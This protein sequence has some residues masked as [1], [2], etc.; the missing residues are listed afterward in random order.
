[1]LLRNIHTKAYFHLAAWL[2]FLLI[3]LFSADELDRLFILKSLASFVPP[4]F[5]FYTLIFWVFPVYLG[6]DN[7]IKTIL[8]TA[9]LAIVMVF[10]R[11]LFTLLFPADL[12]TPFDRITFWVQ[13]RYNI[14]FVAIAFGY[15]YAT[16]IIKSNQKSEWLEKEN[17]AAK[18]ALLKQQ[19]NPHFLYNTLSMNYTKA[20][21]LSDEL[22]E[23]IAKLSDMMRYSITETDAQGMVPLANEIKFI[24]Q[25][26]AMNEA[27]FN[28][29]GNCVFI[30]KSSQ[31]TFKIAP[32]LLISFVENAYKH[33]DLAE[34]IKIELKEENCIFDFS[35]ENKIAKG[36]KDKTSGIGLENIKNRLQLLYKNRHSLLITSNDTDYKIELKLW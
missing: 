36:P 17:T 1:L 29:I 19:I 24:G 3:I 2:G 32:L 5:L 14:L 30:I 21:P 7:D 4:F 34:P 11:P 35:V 26:V 8:L 28:K 27:R 18:L 20:L 22:A 6:K 13:F 15:H 31:S 33:G 12:N 10:L 23:M 9:S 16:E 25:Y